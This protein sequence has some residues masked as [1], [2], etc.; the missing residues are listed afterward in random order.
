MELNNI[1]EYADCIVDILKM[2]KKSKGRICIALKRCLN[3]LLDPTYF[4]GK[5]NVSEKAF[6]EAKIL[7][8]NEKIIYMTW[9]Q[10]GKYKSENNKSG[11]GKRAFILEHYYL[12]SYIKNELFAI[13]NPTRID[14]IKIIKDN[15]KTCIITADEDSKLRK[16]EYSSNRPDPKKAYKE[17]SIRLK[18]SW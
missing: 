11:N 3:E 13:K 5:H 16:L 4:D 6:E 10:L 17:A 1:D 8:I 7:G 12:R 9:H 14:I 15:L 2:V 18:Y